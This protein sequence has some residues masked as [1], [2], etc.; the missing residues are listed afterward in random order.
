V[1]DSGQT[2]S[3]SSNA[4]RGPR[5]PVSLTLSDLDLPRA[6]PDDIFRQ[7]GAFLRFFRTLLFG[8]RN[9]V[10]PAN[11][12]RAA[13]LPEYLLREFHRMPNGYYSYMLVDGY[14]RGFER[15]M[16]GQVELVRRWIAQQLRDC[17][18]VLEIGCGSG[19]LSGAVAAG[20][21]PDVWGIDASPYQLLLALR[22]FPGI[23]F[24]HGVAERTPFADGRFDGIAVCFVFHELP[25]EIQDA[26]LA[27][28]HRL[29]RPGGRIVISEPSPEQLHNRSFVSLWRRHGWRGVYFRMLATFVTEPY[30]EQWH[31][32]DIAA[33]AAQHR[34]AVEKQDCA[35]PFNRIVLRRL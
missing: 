27:E 32:R 7:L 28:M 25:T 4:W 14:E 16:L 33:W 35:V 21:V 34:F 22:R 2:T 23:K 8:G 29:L 31:A 12:P 1:I 30:V 20:G 17:Q 10:L 5:D 15:A 3:R 24:V 26:V 18:S 19:K 6:W 9:V 13:V 11:L